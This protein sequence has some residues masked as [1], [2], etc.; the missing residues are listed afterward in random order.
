[1]QS[2]RTVTGR[3]NFEDR[4]N[5]GPMHT[6]SRPNLCQILDII[7]N[8]LSVHIVIGL[9]FDILSFNCK[10]STLKEGFGHSIFK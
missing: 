4:L 10:L 5:V 6:T 9:Y 7:H 8:M 1:M 3:M 2:I